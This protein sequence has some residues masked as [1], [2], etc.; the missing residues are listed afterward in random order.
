[1]L[2]VLPLS[3][4]VDFSVPVSSEA[5]LRESLM[6]EPRKDLGDKI[7]KA[8]RNI[9]DILSDLGLETNEE[10]RRAVRILGYNRMQINNDNINAIKAADSHSLPA[11]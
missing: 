4:L 6:T 1:M 8:F 3:F 5:L 10:N 11:S 9:D 2:P 7:S